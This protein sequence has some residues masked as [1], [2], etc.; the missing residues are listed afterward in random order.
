MSDSIGVSNAI[1][2]NLQAGTSNEKA[3]EWSFEYSQGSKSVCLKV[4]VENSSSTEI[5]SNSTTLE[6]TL[7]KDDVN[8]IIQWLY[9]AKSNMD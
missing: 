8:Q 1:G 4:Q 9:A 7:K 2:G 6:S 5:S 3:G